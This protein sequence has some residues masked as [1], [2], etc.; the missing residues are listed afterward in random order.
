MWVCSCNN[1]YGTLCGKFFRLGTDRLKVKVIRFWWTGVKGQGHFDVLNKF[2][3][4]T[5]AAELNMYNY[6]KSMFQNFELLCSSIH[7]FALQSTYNGQML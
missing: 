2:L 4:V 5:R 7:I 6:E 3:V 1:V